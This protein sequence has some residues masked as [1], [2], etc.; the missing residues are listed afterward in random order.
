[1]YEETKRVKRNAW[2]LF[3][4]CSVFFWLFVIYLVI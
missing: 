4:V 1:M 3:A 2:K